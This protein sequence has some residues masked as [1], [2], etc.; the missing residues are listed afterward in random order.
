[1]PVRRSDYSSA[2]EFGLTSRAG[3]SRVFALPRRITLYIH[4]DPASEAAQDTKLARK[5]NPKPS[6]SV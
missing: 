1:M 5:I 4:T 2:E 6:Q 3:M